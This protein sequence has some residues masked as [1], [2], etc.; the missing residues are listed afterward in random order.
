[1]TSKGLDAKR[2]LNL[3]FLRVE[4]AFLPYDIMNMAWSAS[5]SLLNQPVLL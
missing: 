2:A 5:P 4:I 1:M 3:C